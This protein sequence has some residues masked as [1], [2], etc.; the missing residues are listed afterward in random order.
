MVE[1]AVLLIFAIFTESLDVAPYIILRTPHFQNFNNNCESWMVGSFGS[2]F[3]GY[4]GVK[5][6]KN[7]VNS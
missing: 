2:G 1:F 5:K 6:T 7:V 4:T 3:S